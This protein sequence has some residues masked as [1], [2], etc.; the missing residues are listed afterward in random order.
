M[1]TQEDIYNVL[2]IISVNYLGKLWEYLS[3]ETLQSIRI[4]KFCHSK[5]VEDFNAAKKDEFSIVA[6]V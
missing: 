2:R 5:I 4:V 1:T 3:L 6:F